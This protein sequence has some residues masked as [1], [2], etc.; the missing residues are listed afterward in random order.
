M[1]AATGLSW[2]VDV[3]VQKKL[4]IR[5]WVGV[6]EGTLRNVTAFS[7]G[8]SPQNASQT[9][10]TEL[11]TVRS[12]VCSHNFLFW[13][14]ASQIESTTATIVSRTL[15]HRERKTSDE[16]IEHKSLRSETSDG[17]SGNKITNNSILI[18]TS[19]LRD[20]TNLITH[21]L[22]LLQLTLSCSST[23]C[24]SLLFLVIV[25][26]G[27]SIIKVWNTT[28]HDKTVASVWFLLVV[29]IILGANVVSENE[30]TLVS[31][32]NK[33]SRI[34]GHLIPLGR[35]WS[36]SFQLR[37]AIIVKT[38]MSIYLISDIAFNRLHN[39]I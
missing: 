28:F 17:K 22:W 25:I 11:V 34:R 7:R 13:P 29:V 14:P 16:E 30:N 1:M 19:K 33:E 39:L 6:W 8:V 37:C 4:N 35:T 27:N 21:Q 18:L 9:V 20:A 38:S 12:I 24:N 26:H 5:V 2:W 31:V 3:G 10:G 36:N 15:V 32:F 23:L